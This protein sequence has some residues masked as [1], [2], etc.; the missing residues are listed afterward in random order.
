MLERTSPLVVARVGVGAGVGAGLFLMPAPEE[1]AEDMAGEGAKAEM[2]ACECIDGELLPPGDMADADEEIDPNTQFVKLNNQF[3]VPVL[4]DGAIV[5]LVVLS[6]SLETGEGGSSIIFQ[7]EPKLRDSFLQVL[8]DH[9]N[10]GGFSGAFTGG[11]RLEQLRT[12]LKR[13]AQ[14]DLGDV[15]RDVLVTDIARQDV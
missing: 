14:R 15:V 9:S 5:S 1:S 6:L 2:G 12:S 10:S 4:E 7:R 3:I 8:F 11:N 13:A